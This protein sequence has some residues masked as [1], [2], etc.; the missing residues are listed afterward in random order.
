MRL[1]ILL[2]SLLAIAALGPTT[3]EAQAGTGDTL[4]ALW[5]VAL[6]TALLVL[7]TVLMSVTQ[8]KKQ[9]LQRKTVVDVRCTSCDYAEKREFAKGDYV[10]KIAGTCPKCGAHLLID[11]IYSKEE[12]QE[13]KAAGAR[14]KLNKTPHNPF[15]TGPT[16][17]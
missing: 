6:I 12:K 2:L 1:W 4:G 17:P 13:G 9:E 16:R 5:S 10:G 7:V 8:P 14:G 11:T 15:R 3:V